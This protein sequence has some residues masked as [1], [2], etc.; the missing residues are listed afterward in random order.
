[1]QSDIIVTPTL[2]TLAKPREIE[3]WSVVQYGKIDQQAVYSRQTK[4]WVLRT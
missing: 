3:N 2:Y 1:M 4:S